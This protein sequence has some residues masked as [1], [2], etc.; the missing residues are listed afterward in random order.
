MQIQ[1][2][3]KDKGKDKDVDPFTKTMQ[4]QCKFK[5]K[6]KDKDADPFTK[7][8]QIQYKNKD[9]DKDADPFTPFFHNSPLSYLKLDS[10]RNTNTKTKRLR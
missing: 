6:D 8:V 2:K 7:T 10:L 1:C 3:Y 5:D 4:I 9:K